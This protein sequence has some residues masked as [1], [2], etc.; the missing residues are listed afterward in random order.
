MLL[1]VFIVNDSGHDFSRASFF[2]TLIPLSHGTID[3]YDVTKMSRTFEPF[4]TTSSPLDYILCSGPAVMNMVVCAMFASLH[5]RINLLLWREG[6][7]E[8]GH[9]INTPLVLAG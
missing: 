5:H 7:D 1:K 8:P 3:K 2:G 9:Y 6:Q 4:L